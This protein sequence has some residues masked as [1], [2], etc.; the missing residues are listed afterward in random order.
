M[1][2]MNYENQNMYSERYNFFQLIFSLPYFF[3]TASSCSSLQFFD[4]VHFV[5]VLK[6]YNGGQLDLL[7][8]SVSI[9]FLFFYGLSNFPRIMY[10]VRFH[11]SISSHDAT[12]VSLIHLT[13]VFSIFIFRTSL[14]DVLETKKI[15]SSILLCNRIYLF[16]LSYKRFFFSIRY[17]QDFFRFDFFC[18]P[19]KY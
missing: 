6:I 16:N 12:K 15:S 18:K 4:P 14:F 5:V 2:T 1:R 9:W 3:Q 19:R 10:G 17:L 13:N 11:I 8:Y 7:V